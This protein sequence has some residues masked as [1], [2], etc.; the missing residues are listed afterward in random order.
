[1]RLDNF[2]STH[3]Q[4]QVNAEY[5]FLVPMILMQNIFSRRLYAVKNVTG[6]FVSV[7]F[8]MKQICV[9][10][11]FF[12][13]RNKKP[14]QNELINCNYSKFNLTFFFIQSDKANGICLIVLIT[15]GVMV[16]HR[17]FNIGI[18]TFVNVSGILISACSL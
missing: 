14:N 18:A 12:F 6:F 4:L 17:F 2:F 13:F 16:E 9:L 3:A 10:I 11:R 5:N 1:M 15:V 7:C 8:V